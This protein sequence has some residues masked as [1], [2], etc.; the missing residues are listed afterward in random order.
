MKKIKISPPALFL[1][2]ALLALTIANTGCT[3][4]A[5]KA[6]HEKRADQFYAAGQFDRAEIEYENVLHN[7]PLDPQAISRLGLI[8]FQ[9]GRVRNAFIY[10]RK[11]GEL[12][13]NDL[14]VRLKL[15][16][17]YAALNQPGEARMTADFVLDQ[18]PLDDDAPL[19][20]A[21]TVGTPKEMAAARARL[22]KLAAAGDRAA[23]EVALGTL[24]FRERDFKNAAAS[25]Q[26]ALT[27]DPKSSQAFASLGLL[28]ATQK[29]LTNALI[30]FNSAAEFAPERSPLK[31]L[32]ARFKVETGDAAGGRQI[33]EEMVKR[34]PD[35][36][37]ALMGLAGIALS[38][39]KYDDSQGYLD[40]VLARD[41]DNLDGMMLDS[42]LKLAKGD[43]SAAT[44][45]LER[46]TQIY[47]Q[48]PG[49]YYQLAQAY[50]SANDTAKATL[51]LGHALDLNPDFADAIM[52]LA[53]IQ[54]RSQN[55]SPAVFSLEKLV[56][57]QPQLVR[58]QLLLADVYRQNKRVA[59]AMAIYTSLEENYPQN[60]QLP[61]L[62]GS[63][64]AQQNDDADARR[65]FTRALTLAPDSPVALEQLENLDL[66]EKQFDAAMQRVQ[67]RLSADPNNVS[68]YILQAKVYLAEE[69]RDQAEATL[70]KAIQVGPDNPGV[71]LLLA[72]LYLDSKQ[73]DKA[74]AQLDTTLAKDPKNLS[75]LMLKATIYGSSKDYDQQ[76][77]T[78][79]KMLAIDPK[80]T[81]ALNNLACLYAQ[82][83]RQLDRAYDLAQQARTLMPFDP[84]AADTLGWICYLRG[85]FPAALSL[86]QESAAK[87]PNEPENQFHLGMV[88]YVMGKDDAARAAFQSALQINQDFPEQ[89]ECKTCLAILNINPQ[90]ADAAAIAVL[91]R[92]VAQ[93]SNDPIA[94]GRLAAI[95]Q[96]AGNT[97]KAIASYEAVLQAAPNNVSAML[98][99]A[100]LYA[101]KDAAKAYDLARTAYKLASDNPIAA[102]I[103]GQLTYQ[104]GDFKLANTLLQQTVQNQNSDPQAFFELAQ[105]AYSLGKISDAQAALQNALQLNL[106]AP[107][108]TEA[109]RML[110]LI[111]LAADSAQA[112]AAT[113]QVA[114]I[115]KSEPDYVPALMTAGVIDERNANAAAAE[116]AYEKILARYPDFSPAQR[117]LAILY[118]KDSTKLDRAYDLVSKART[119]YPDDAVLAKA[120]GIIVFQQGDFSRAASLLKG[121]AINLP[122]DAEVFYYLGA[123][124]FKLKDNAASKASLQQAL[125]LNLSGSQA[126]AAKQLLGQLK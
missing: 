96:R 12:A 18:K 63:A 112:V 42:Q 38:E 73:N 121:V 35:Y 106:P 65:E 74:M 43:L 14:T 39:K 72:Q 34:T 46:G 97:D 98:N 69:K 104:H 53:Q 94:L 52:L 26:R 101:P 85:S 54:I 51:N 107:Q 21:Q 118:S 60:P 2:A 80:C 124:Q 30:N 5:K 36:I 84:N 50:L 100:Q 92:R 68:L 4:K 125:A 23:L 47:P 126:D 111:N 1:L 119:I 24:S 25:Y 81:P 117:Q 40:K 88:N 99:L 86:L 55:S 37:P 79:E 45:E 103:Y 109:Q 93:K 120:T 27:L 110:N 8:Y 19:L 64:Y 11:A 78:Y 32:C 66:A 89:D 7:A 22:Q 10:L 76:T 122:N 123:A 116:I 3:A 59:D 90:T 67:S 13:T 16:L 75:A 33:L 49:I 28:D 58:A 61:L 114:Q 87:L 113:A 62:L 9:Q 105:S 41:P 31:V 15:G 82:N 56:Q 102:H 71:Y 48:V 83:P 70:L 57:K 91:E 115:L 29:D 6:Y 20:L 77:D 44:G 17:L 108:S 95:Y